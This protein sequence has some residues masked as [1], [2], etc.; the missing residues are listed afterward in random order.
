MKLMDVLI[1]IAKNKRFIILITFFASVASFGIACLF[2]KIYYTELRVRVDDSNSTKFNILSDMNKNLSS[3]FGDPF[4]DET[5]ELFLE[6][7]EGRENLLLAIK[8]FKLDSLYKKK[9]MDLILKSFVKDLNIGVSNNG[10]IY[11]GYKGEDRDLAVKLV[12]TIVLEADKRYI[13]LQKER[14]ELNRDFLLEKQQ[15]LID[16]L[17]SINK[18]LISFYKNNNVINIEKQIEISLAALSTYESKLKTFKIDQKLIRKSLGPGISIDEKY[19]D[20]ISILQDEFNTLR[21]KNKSDYQ[22]SRKSV[23]INTDWGLEK[24]L[25]EK[26]K[27]NQIQILRDFIGVISKELALAEAQ[28]SR[29]T[30]VIQI[31]QDAYY[32]DWKTQPKRAKWAIAAF[33]ISF[34]LSTSYIVL[35]ALIHD[36]IPG[37]GNGQ[38]LK[39][40]ISAMKP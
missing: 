8:R 13:K 32:P 40:L 22:P 28:V 37:N 31:V 23:F 29:S 38:R 15:Q 30:P 26:I 18:E 19:K 6:I 5:A 2:P 35:R 25:F 10:I 12:K 36:E 34:C 21:E 24:L 9:S 7:L 16:S 33:L 39:E 1:L 14:Q 4:Q 27:L 17:E 20:I 11:C 3:L